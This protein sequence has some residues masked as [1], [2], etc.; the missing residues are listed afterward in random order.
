MRFTTKRRLALD[1]PQ[2]EVQYLHAGSHPP[3]LIHR[4]AAPDE[5]DRVPAI[6]AMG[7]NGVPPSLVRRAIDERWSVDEAARTFRHRAK[8]G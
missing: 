5:S 3:T 1:Q 6:L 8:V 4:Q 2:A 7:S